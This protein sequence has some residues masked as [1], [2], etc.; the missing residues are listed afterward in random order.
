MGIVGSYELCCDMFQWRGAV[1]FDEDERN[2]KQIMPSG[3]QLSK[4][5]SLQLL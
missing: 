1:H 4:T 5:S 3:D 2:K